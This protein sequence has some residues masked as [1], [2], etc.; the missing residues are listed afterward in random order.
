MMGALLWLTISLPFVYAGQ[1]EI[2]KQQQSENSNFPLA[3]NEEESKDESE[4]HDPDPLVIHRR[5][6]ALQTLR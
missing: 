2:A 4:I 6:P 1:Q 3:G 5:E